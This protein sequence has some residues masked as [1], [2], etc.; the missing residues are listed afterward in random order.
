MFIKHSRGPHTLLYANGSIDGIGLRYRV[1]KNQP[2]LIGYEYTHQSN[3][4][5]LSIRGEDM[6]DMIA[7]FKRGNQVAFRVTS[8]N[9]FVESGTDRVSLSGFTRAYNLAKDCNF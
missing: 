6:V 4:D 1:D 3:N 5:F 9:Q 7:A 8:G 2:V